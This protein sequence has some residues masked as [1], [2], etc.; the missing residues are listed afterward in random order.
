M[1]ELEQNPHADEPVSGPAVYNAPNEGAHGDAGHTDAEHGG[2]AHGGE[3]L[4][5]DR[6]EGIW[7][8]IAIGVLSLFLLAVTISSFVWGIQLPGYYQRVNPTT[9]N[10]EGSPFANPQ[11]RELAPG[12]YEAYIRA[13]V[14][15][16][17]PAEIRVPVG[18]QVT[19]YITSQDVQH[20]FKL[21]NTNVNVMVLPGQISTLSHTFNEVGEYNYVCHEYCGLN[22]HTM[23]GRV[24]V[25]PQPADSTVATAD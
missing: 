1:S 17:T 21:M 24:I 3:S 11:L 8:R 5:I 6:I 7:M 23:F 4:H 15:S 20:G 13:Q 2:A 22:H 16:F 19:F 25:E 14:W 18:S 12:K 9:L 10:D